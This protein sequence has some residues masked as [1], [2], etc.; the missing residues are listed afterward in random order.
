[1]K[2]LILAL[3]ML[4][5]YASAKEALLTLDSNAPKKVENCRC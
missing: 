1:M 3:L 4:C 5:S 2:N